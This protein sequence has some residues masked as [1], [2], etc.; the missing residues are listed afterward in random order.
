[1]TT[2]PVPDIIPEI[3]KWLDANL[4]KITSFWLHADWRGW[5]RFDLYAH[6]AKGMCREVR[7]DHPRWDYVVSHSVRVW[8]ENDPE[9]DLTVE[10]AANQNLDNVAIWI[11][12]ATP[13]ENDTSFPNFVEKFQREW[14]L[15]QDLTKKTGGSDGDFQGGKL[16]FLGIGEKAYDEEEL[17]FGDLKPQYFGFGGRTEYEVAVYMYYLWLDL[18]VGES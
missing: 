11:C 10:P 4:E 12:T 1:M 8:G 16:L 14:K 9:V 3:K 5:A 6:L 13:G 7:P 18:P 17:A 15:V 2:R